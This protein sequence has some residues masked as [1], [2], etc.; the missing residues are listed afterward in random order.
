MLPVL[1][2]ER[3]GQD[4]A[5][6]S[7]D[8]PEMRNDLQSCRQRGPQR[9]PRDTNDPEAKQPEEADSQRVLQLTDS[10]VLQSGGSDSDVIGGCHSFAVAVVVTVQVRPKT[11]WQ[12][13][14]ARLA[15]PQVG[16][17]RNAPPGWRWC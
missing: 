13:L 16:S 8:G 11:S 9:S 2:T 4:R 17:T 6:Q 1:P 15:L 14:P 7:E 12:I 10:P 3:G 5:K